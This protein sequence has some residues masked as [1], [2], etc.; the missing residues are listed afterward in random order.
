MEVVRGRRLCEAVN[1]EI[2][3]SAVE[4]SFPELAVVFRLRC[5]SMSSSDCCFRGC[6]NADSCVDSVRS[7]PALRLVDAFSKRD[8]SDFLE[9]GVDFGVV[10]ALRSVSFL[11]SEKVMMRF[12]V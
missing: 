9:F 12:F 10:A 2:G 1:D 11:F 8:V 4:S 7:I 5:L 6:L 3:L